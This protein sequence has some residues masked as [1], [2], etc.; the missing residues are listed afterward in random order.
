MS[1]QYYLWCGKKLMKWS[2][3]KTMSTLFLI[4]LVSC[5]YCLWN[6]KNKTI[7][8]MS[9]FN[10]LYTF[11]LMWNF[12]KYKNNIFHW[13]WHYKNIWLVTSKIYTVKTSQDKTIKFYI[14]TPKQRFE[15]GPNACLHLPSKKRLRWYRQQKKKWQTSTEFAKSR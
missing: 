1:C 4:Q 9:Y 3:D 12:W 15:E 8:C 7:N 5:M 2:D 6:K 13:K 14:S 10:Q 11:L